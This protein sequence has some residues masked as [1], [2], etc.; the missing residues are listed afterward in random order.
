MQQLLTHQSLGVSNALACA[1]YRTVLM[2]QDVTHRMTAP[3]KLAN[4]KPRYSIVWKLLFIPKDP[5]ITPSIARPEWGP[6]L[7]MS[8]FKPASV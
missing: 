5:T 6:P 7:Q 4:G 1:R 3:S 8:G 2:D